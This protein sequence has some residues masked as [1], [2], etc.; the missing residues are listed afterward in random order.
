MSRQEWAAAATQNLLK[1]D[2]ARVRKAVAAQ[3]RKDAAAPMRKAH[4]SAWAPKQ[5]SSG[6]AA[7]VPEQRGLGFSVATPL[8]PFTDGNCFFNGSAGGFFGSG[9]QSPFGQPWNS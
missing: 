5:S 4:G 3:S 8:R 9:G 1:V 6:W 7:R 2:A